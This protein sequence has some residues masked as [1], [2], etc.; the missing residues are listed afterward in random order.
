MIADKK[1]FL[2]GSGLLIGFAAVFFIMF[3]PIFGAGQNALN[4]FDN[5]FNSISKGS[6]YYI[7]DLAEQNETYKNRDVT[8]TIY[9]GSPTQT[10]HT[11]VLFQKTGAAV[12]TDDSQITIKGDLGTILA[13]A[14]QD[15]D[16]L[17]PP[18]LLVFCLL[19]ASQLT[20]KRVSLS[21]RLP[22]GWLGRSFTGSVGI[23]LPLLLH[24]GVSSLQ[25]GPFLA[26]RIKID[27]ANIPIL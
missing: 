14:I 9:A 12:E 26:T 8:V 27:P 22:S 1:T 13:A 10:E 15:A 24:V 20:R 16:L 4:Y 3:M 7:P 19:I 18:K 6:A 17:F 2:I 23:S 11:A 5:L 25:F 21:L